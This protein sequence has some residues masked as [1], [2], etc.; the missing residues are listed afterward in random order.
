MSDEMRGI[1][2]RHPWVKDWNPQVPPYKSQADLTA[3]DQRCYVVKEALKD[4]L[5]RN[6]KILK[7]DVYL[8]CS[9][10]NPHHHRWFLEEVVVYMVCNSHK[11][12]AIHINNIVKK[13]GF[14]TVVAGVNDAI[15]KNKV[16]HEQRLKRE[17]QVEESRL[18]RLDQKEYERK[19]KEESQE[20]HR[21]QLEEREARQLKELEAEQE[22]R[23]KDEEWERSWRVAASVRIP[24]FASVGKTGQGK[25]L[26]GIERDG[27][28][29]PRRLRRVLRLLG[30][31]LKVF[32][33]II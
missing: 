4:L 1:E 6:F 20:R 33:R 10:R 18:I 22:K 21:K 19:W 13:Y 11:N 31:A 24:G 30:Q 32:E 12:P 17:K 8:V 9:S 15:E 7:E 23:R 26:V 2:R 28:K 5:G 16:L 14:A 3:S 29:R 25:S 27:M